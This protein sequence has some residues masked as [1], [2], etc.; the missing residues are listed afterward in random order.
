MGT[1]EAINLAQNYALAV[2]Q[3]YP[4]ADIYLFGSHASGTARSDS[5]IDIAVVVKKLE[6]NWLDK[7]AQLWRLSQKVDSHIEPV[8]LEADY[9]Q[10]GFVAHIRQTGTPL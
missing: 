9:D 10:S 2:R 4:K 8:L 6:G 1:A 7:S 3:E 5:D